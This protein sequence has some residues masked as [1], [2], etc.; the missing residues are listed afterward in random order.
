MVYKSPWF[1]SSSFICFLMGAAA[2]LFFCIAGA[3]FSLSTVIVPACV[4]AV[5]AIRTFKECL[6]LEM[7]E[8]CLILRNRILPG[9]KTEIAADD[10]KS[11]L[12]MPPRGN[13]AWVLY[14]TVRNGK[15]KKF[16]LG[17]VPSAALHP[18]E[19]ELSNKVKG[20]AH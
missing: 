3:F 6:F 4:F 13:G 19:E 10:M 8:E 14:V 17:C 9:L 11:F 15:R 7:K 20:H 16:V 5:Y 2:F 18:L 1:K 12:L